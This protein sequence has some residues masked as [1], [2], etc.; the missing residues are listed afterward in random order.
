[1]VAW[2]NSSRL[3]LWPNKLI[4]ATLP[5][6]LREHPQEPT[7]YESCRGPQPCTLNR[8]PNQ[9]NGTHRATKSNGGPSCNITL[10]QTIPWGAWH[11]IAL[12]AWTYKSWISIFLLQQI[13]FSQLISCKNHLYC[14]YGC[15]KLEP[16][17]TLTVSVYQTSHALPTLAS[18]YAGAKTCECSVPLEAHVLLSRDLA[19]ELQAP[20]KLWV[21]RGGA[22]RYH[23]A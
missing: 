10:W 7:V 16:H 9:G 17:N 1:V 23:E 8:Q 20:A 2:E 22:I 4:S 11:D 18:V 21:W 6:G 12:F 3:F 19:H 14:M 5:S 13:S 15:Y